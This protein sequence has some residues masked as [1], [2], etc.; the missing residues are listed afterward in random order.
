MRG[1][2]AGSS[3]EPSPH[4]PA[5]SSSLQSQRALL[6]PASVCPGLELSCRLTDE[7]KSAPSGDLARHGSWAPKIKRIIETYR[8]RPNSGD[9]TR[10]SPEEV[11]RYVLERLRTN[12][13]QTDPHWRPQHLQCPFCLVNF[14]VYA[15]MEELQENTVYFSL[16]S[17]L[18]HKLDLD[19]KKNS[20]RNDDRSLGN[21]GEG[22]HFLN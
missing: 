19:L 5:L 7:P 17:N 18:K 10:P 22:N 14:T 16:R 12:K 1:Q 6:Q 2:E 4:R 15:K 3:E 9:L 21:G 20:M 8:A 13:R 11:V